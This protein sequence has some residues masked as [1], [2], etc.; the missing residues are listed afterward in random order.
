MRRRLAVALVAAAAAIANRII[1]RPEVPADT[2]PLTEDEMRDYHAA[3]SAC[4]R[5]CVEAREGMQSLDFATWESQC[6]VGGEQ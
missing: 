5:E 4:V 2:W 1:T 6:A 3:W